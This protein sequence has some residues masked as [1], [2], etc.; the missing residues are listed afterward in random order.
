MPD[1]PRR[2]RSAQ[3]CDRARGAGRPNTLRSIPHVRR[4]AQLTCASMLAL[5]V[6]VATLLA[7]TAPV[8]P[9]ASARAASTPRCATSELVMWVNAE[10]SGTAG[11]FYYKIEFANLSGRTCTL[12]GYPGVSAV[13]LRGRQIG[14]PAGREVTQKP[15]VVTLAPEAQTTAIVRVI[16]VGALPASCRP[17][18]AAGFRIHP[19]GQGTS[20]LVPFPFRT[21]SKVGQSPMS[22]RAVKSE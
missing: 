13:N 4:S 9:A 6:S 17:A 12:A 20:K 8:A 5:L 19:P 16:D 2:A 14:S 1:E 7:T 15:R 10:G 11:S 18:T 22:V 21:C 3:T